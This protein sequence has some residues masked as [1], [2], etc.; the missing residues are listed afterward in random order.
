MNFNGTDLF[1]Y[2]VQACRVNWIDLDNFT[3]EWL[4]EGPGLAADL[5]P[6]DS[7]RVDSFDYSVFADY[8]L[9][10]CDDDWPLK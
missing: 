1:G 10:F 5:Y 6:T 4:D 8:W 3:D 9:A 2:N 7:N